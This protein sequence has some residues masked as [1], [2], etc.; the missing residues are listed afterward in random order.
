MDRIKRHGER[1]KMERSELAEIVRSLNYD[2]EDYRGFVFDCCSMS[3]IVFEELQKR[4]LKP[5]I[6]SGREPGERVGHTW[7]E[8]GKWEIESTQKWVG[9]K[10]NE[11]E[12]S[13]RLHKF[14]TKEEYIKFLPWEDA[15]QRVRDPWGGIREIKEVLMEWKSAGEFVKISRKALE[16]EDFEI[17]ENGRRIK[18]ILEGSYFDIKV[19]RKNW[20]EMALARMYFKK[21]SWHGDLTKGEGKLEWKNFGRILFDWAKVKVERNSVIYKG[22]EVEW[23]FKGLVRDLKERRF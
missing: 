1:M 16:Q 5:L 11:R 6:C 13:E 9:A 18:G 12:F 19:A 22:K 21:K 3:A 23:S 20:R 17:A 4:G 7:V 2:T 10:S 8:C 15:K 14:K